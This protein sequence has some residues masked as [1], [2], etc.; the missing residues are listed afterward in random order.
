MSRTL[1][2]VLLEVGLLAL[3]WVVGIVLVA[4]GWLVGWLGWLVWR[5]FYLAWEGHPRESWDVD[6]WPHRPG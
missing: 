1:Q 5:L 4:V 2:L 6:E 3:A